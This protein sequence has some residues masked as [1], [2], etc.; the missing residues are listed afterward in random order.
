MRAGDTDDLS[1]EL[2]SVGGNDDSGKTIFRIFSMIS[3]A[4]DSKC[5][6]SNKKSSYSLR[7]SVKMVKRFKKLMKS[8]NIMTIN[9]YCKALLHVSE[10]VSH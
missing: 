9:L 8:V 7:N 10:A 2:D 4:T 6:L 3:V 5:E 1:A